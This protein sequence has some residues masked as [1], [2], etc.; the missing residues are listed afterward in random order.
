MLVKCELLRLSAHCKTA[1]SVLQQ[2][3]TMLCV[4]VCVCVCVCMYVSSGFTMPTIDLYGVTLTL[5]V[6]N[7]TPV[8]QCH[9]ARCFQCYVTLKSA[10]LHCKT[11]IVLRRYTLCV[12]S[13]RLLVV[14]LSLCHDVR[15][16]VCSVLCYWW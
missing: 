4:C 2:Q 14:K 16:F 3:S 15:P 7:P 10:M 6:E 8:Y 12:F 1:V 11:L 9:D 13:F 5:R